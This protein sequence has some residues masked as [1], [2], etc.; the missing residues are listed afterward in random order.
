MKTRKE[1]KFLA[2]SVNSVENIRFQKKIIKK[3]KI[4]FRKTTQNTNQN[5]KERNSVKRKFQTKQKILLQK[6]NN[7]NK[8]YKAFKAKKFKRKYMRSS[9]D[10]L[11]TRN[12]KKK[13]MQ[14]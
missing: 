11:Q 3:K 5:E 7:S 2:N 6:L 13:Y 4:R 8:K 14:K 9:R 1:S 12:K 10:E